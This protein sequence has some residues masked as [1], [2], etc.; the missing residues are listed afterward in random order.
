MKIEETGLA[1][2]VGGNYLSSDRAYFSIVFIRLLPGN[3]FGFPG[4]MRPGFEG[5]MRK[6]LCKARNQERNRNDNYRRRRYCNVFPAMFHFNER[7]DMDFGS[8][9]NTDRYKRYIRLVTPCR[10]AASRSPRARR[11]KERA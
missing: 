1:A 11:K 7:I 4:D 2:V 9:E 8:Q 3:D 6:F 10:F 5:G